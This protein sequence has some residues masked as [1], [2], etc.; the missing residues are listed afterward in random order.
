MR[1]AHQV[2]DEVTESLYPL[3]TYH[4]TL[5]HSEEPGGTW[6]QTQTQTQS[7]SQSQAPS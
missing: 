3:H 1:I 4:F 5:P 6:A 2:S 7:Q